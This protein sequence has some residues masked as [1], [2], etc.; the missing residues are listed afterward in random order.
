MGPWEMGLILPTHD[1]RSKFCDFHDCQQY[2]IPNT[3][4][5]DEEFY[6]Q[7]RM[8]FTNKEN[9]N[10]KSNVRQVPPAEV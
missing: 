8:A 5:E 9:K 4:D 2:L 3:W 6:F 1:W 7:I 10:T